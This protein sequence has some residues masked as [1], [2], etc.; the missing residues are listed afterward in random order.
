MIHGRFVV[1]LTAL[2]AGGC[3]MHNINYDPPP[4]KPIT[5]D[6]TPNAVLAAFTREYP[7]GQIEGVESRSSLNDG[8]RYQIIFQS[9]DERREVVFR[10]DGTMLDGSDRVRDRR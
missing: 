1:C 10:E 3:A 8:Q 6:K 7:A 4:Y 5:L 9:G 2:L